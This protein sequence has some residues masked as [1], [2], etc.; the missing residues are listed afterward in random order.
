M[1]QGERKSRFIVTRDG[2]E[3]SGYFSWGYRGQG[4]LN[5]ATEIVGAVLAHA[6]CEEVIQHLPQWRGWTITQ[7]EVD[8]WKT[9]K[10]PVA[11]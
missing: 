6:Y 8:E 7:A 3:V 9:K 11:K 10:Q 5:L 1:W 4:C 2:V